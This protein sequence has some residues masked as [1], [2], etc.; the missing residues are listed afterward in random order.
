MILE[1]QSGE[2][3][4]DF[5]NRII[6]YIVEHHEGV[7][8]TISQPNDNITII[9]HDDPM[10]HKYAGVKRTTLIQLILDKIKEEREK[11]DDA[12]HKCHEANMISEV[13]YKIRCE[14]M[15]KVATDV[16]L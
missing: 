13:V 14:A 3:L 4:T 8:A 5:I 12:F 10:I 16:I 2:I 6:D 11:R 7:K 15:A 1:I 9:I